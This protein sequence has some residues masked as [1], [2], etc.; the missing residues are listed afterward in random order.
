M[1]WVFLF[2]AIVAEVCGTT[3]MKLSD[4]FQR[5]LPTVLMFI[6]YLLSLSL[7]NLAMRTIGI[8]TAYAIWSGVG[9]ALIASIGVAYFKEPMTLVKV[10][11][12]ALIIFGVIGLNLTG[13]HS[14]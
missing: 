9:T 6:F 1:Q 2:S 12:L 13:T 10:L 7:M 8:A 3:S 11:S 14:G 4:G 5:P